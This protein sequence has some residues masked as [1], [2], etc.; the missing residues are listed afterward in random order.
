MGVKTEGKAFDG[1]GKWQIPLH[2]ILILKHSTK[3]W[4]LATRKLHS[5]GKSPVTSVPRVCC[6]TDSCY[7]HGVSDMR[8][9]LFVVFTFKSVIKTG[10][11]L[12]VRVDTDHLRPGRRGTA[13][14]GKSL[15]S[16][17][18]VLRC[19]L[20]SYTTNV[21]TNLKK[22]SRTHTGERPYACP[23]CPFRASQTENLK[24][25]IRTHTG[26]KPYACTHCPYRAT[27]KSSLK[28]HLWVH[29]S[30]GY[31]NE[32]WV[33]DSFHPYKWLFYLVSQGQ[34]N[35]EVNTGKKLL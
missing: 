27:E 15:S 17:G 32:P 10:N 7:S 1:F 34:H 24:R 19:S 26:E 2:K 31:V 8:L 33:S 35:P 3:V 12:Q 6:N 29:H 9:S 30:S 16:S 13:G 18:R 20:C 28:N 14:A 4:S 11:P 21:H 25:H 22:H 5:S 23:Y